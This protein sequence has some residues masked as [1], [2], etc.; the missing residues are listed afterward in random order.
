MREQLG[1]LNRLLADGHI[2]YTK[3]E[4]ITEYEGDNFM[5]I[6]KIYEGQYENLPR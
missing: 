6:Q 3:Q 4:I 1:V 5:E 2:V